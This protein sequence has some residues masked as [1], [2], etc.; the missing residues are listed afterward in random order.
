MSKPSIIL[1]ENKGRARLKMAWAHRLS[2]LFIDRKQMGRVIST[3]SAKQ[4]TASGFMASEGM[5]ATPACLSF[6]SHR[7][8]SYIYMVSFEPPYSGYSH[9]GRCYPAPSS[10]EETEAWSLGTMLRVTCEVRASGSSHSQSG[11]TYWEWL[12]LLT[13]VP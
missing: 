10:D 5:M 9:L 1:P 12:V 11:F 7:M 6:H 4:P 8:L 13:S 3:P 2:R